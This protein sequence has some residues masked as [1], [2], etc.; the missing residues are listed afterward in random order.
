MSNS[1]RI[2]TPDSPTP[3]ET[4]SL[5][6]R[7]ELGELIVFPLCPFDFSNQEERTFLCSQKLASGTHKNISFDPKTSK[8]AG[9]RH[10]SDTQADRLVSLCKRFSESASE[11]FKQILPEYSK[12]IAFDRVS[13]RNEEEAI[14]PLRLSA[15]NDLLHIDNFPTR[16][17]FG[18]RI[19]RLYVNINPTEERVWTTSEGIASL[20]KRFDEVQQIPQ[21]SREQWL[22]I[23]QALHRLLHGEWVSRS[24]YDSFMLK[25]HHFLKCDESFQE[26]ASRKFWH[27]P[28]MSAWLLF[29]D[30][31]AHAELRG[32][33]AFEH[34]FFISNEVL[35]LR[36]QSPLE[37]LVRFRSSQGFRQAG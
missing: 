18:K 24:Y 23:P 36:E 29:S 31:L 5:A 35:L 27:L 11:W 2:P 3:R 19:L 25:L 37:Q 1:M 10:Q 13:L 22:S 9:I 32:Q 7:L 34:S 26:Q 17:T 14:R 15:R 28:P 16:P 20:L 33:F 21:K 12:G 4:S 8:L 30:A 6:E